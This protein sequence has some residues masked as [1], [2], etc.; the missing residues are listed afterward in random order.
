M[1][2]A[3]IG[4]NPEERSLTSCFTAGSSLVEAGAI[5]EEWVESVTSELTELRSNVR[6]V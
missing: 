6:G 4:G 3:T 5:G 2:Y 1:S